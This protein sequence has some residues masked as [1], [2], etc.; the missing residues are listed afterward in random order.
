M[1]LPAYITTVLSVASLTLGAPPET[2]KSQVA[3]TFFGEKVTED[4]RW[5]ED[6]KNA[7]VTEWSKAQ[8][9]HARG[10]LESLPNVKAIEKRVT[11]I[12]A[13][14]TVSYGGV[15]HRNGTFFAINTTAQSA[16]CEDNGERSIL[17]L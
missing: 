3:D 12:L 11:E 17:S 2:R 15:S 16:W 6:S 8:N 14:R 13:A 9:V 1:N 10:V 5:L 7:E 4:Y